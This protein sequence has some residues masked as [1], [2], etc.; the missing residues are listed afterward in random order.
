MSEHCWQCAVAEEQGWPKPHAPGRDCKH[1]HLARSCDT[2][3]AEA[4][5]DELRAAL[6]DLREAAAAIVLL[7]DTGHGGAIDALAAMLPRID[8]LIG[9]YGE[10]GGGQ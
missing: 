2:C 9:P 4:E 6:R 8:A 3:D 7:T 5:R 10:Q 1:G